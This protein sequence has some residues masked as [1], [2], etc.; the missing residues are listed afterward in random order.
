MTIEEMMAQAA[1]AREEE[2]MQ[3][4]SYDSVGALLL[5]YRRVRSKEVM[6]DELA[7]P[8]P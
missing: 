4:L 7:D 8:D 1:A 2:A 5:D 3:S 6:L